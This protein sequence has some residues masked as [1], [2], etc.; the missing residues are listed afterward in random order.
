M[1]GYSFNLEL[2]HDGLL[3]ILFPPN[4]NTLGSLTDNHSLSLRFF[5]YA[6]M[7]FQIIT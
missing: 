7:M 4:Q 1:E 3:H 5:D 2:W 6:Q